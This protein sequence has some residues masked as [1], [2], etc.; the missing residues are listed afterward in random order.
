MCGNCF[1]EVFRTCWSAAWHALDL[2]Q[3]DDWAF[4]ISCVPKDDCGDKQIQT[5]GMLAHLSPLD[6]EHVNLTGDYVWDVQQRAKRR[7][8]LS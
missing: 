1:G 2:A 7:K 6:W 4:Q 8:T 3:C 5:A